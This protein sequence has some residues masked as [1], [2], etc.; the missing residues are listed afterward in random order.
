[1]FC[2]QLSVHII[3]CCC[4]FQAYY[5]LAKEYHPDKNPEAGDKVKL[6]SSCVPVDMMVIN[7]SWLITRLV[8]G[9]FITCKILDHWACWNLG[10]T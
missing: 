8:E 2:Q 1:M 3:S 10:L 4:I 6:K 5:K 7:L 9:L